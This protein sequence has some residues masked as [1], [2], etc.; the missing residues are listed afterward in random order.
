MQEGWKYGRIG[1]KDQWIDGRR[2]YRYLLGEHDFPFRK[3]KWPS[4]G[5]GNPP[6]SQCLELLGGPN[7]H[8]EWFDAL[9]FPTVDEFTVYQEVMLK[10]ESTL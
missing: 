7:N 8:K 2:F 5:G 1:P 3:L 9:P 4:K 10:S 6:K